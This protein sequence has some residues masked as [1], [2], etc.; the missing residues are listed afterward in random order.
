MSPGFEL[1][2][3]GI[4]D[5]FVD[6][7]VGVLVAVNVGVDVN[8]GVLVAVNVGVLVGVGVNVLVNVGVLVGVG[9]NVLVGVGVGVPT[10]V[11]GV[12]VGVGQKVLSSKNFALL[13]KTLSIFEMLT[14]K[15]LF[16]LVI[17]AI[18]ISIMLT[19]S[20]LVKD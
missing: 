13:F 16:N 18:T 1:V 17:I 7:R 11:V 15:T 8:V 20:N 9:V 5:E 3:V 12:G 6:V 4:G 2:G 10:G 19:Q 14:H